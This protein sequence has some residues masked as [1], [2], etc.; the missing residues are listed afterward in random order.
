MWITFNGRRGNKIY[1][2][3]IQSL[4]FFGDFLPCHFLFRGLNWYLVMWASS[5]NV[6]AVAF[7]L[8]A[9][10]FWF[11]SVG[12]ILQI[13]MAFLKDFFDSCACPSDW[14]SSPSKLKL[15][16]TAAL[17]DSCVL[18]WLGQWKENQVLAALWDTLHMNSP[19]LKI[20]R[21]IKDLL[22]RMHS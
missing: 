5:K 4:V 13:A 15:L 22:P 19:C 9:A 2:Y 18:F 3:Y 20:F 1:I 21:K 7:F 14:P 16:L 17:E 8:R 10:V 6:F 11:F 12:F